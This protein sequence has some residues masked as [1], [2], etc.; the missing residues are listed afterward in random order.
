MKYFILPSL[1]LAALLFAP[2]AFAA[3]G[4]VPLTSIP[5]VDSV[6][7]AD[8]LAAFLNS[9]YK[10]AIGA[11][12]VLAVFQIIR[13]G[14]MYM[15][16]GSVLEK[17]EAKHHIFMAVVGLVLVLSPA[18]VF[19]II[20]PKI[21]DLNIG[22]DQLTP[23]NSQG[24]PG[25]DEG[26][27]GEDEGTDNGGAAEDTTVPQTLE[28]CAEN[29]GRWIVSAES[30]NGRCIIVTD[31]SDEAL[32]DEEQIDTT[33]GVTGTPYTGS[34][35]V[36]A[37]SKFV[38]YRTRNVPEWGCNLLS[39]VYFDS[40]A[41]TAAVCQARGAETG[42]TAINGAVCIPEG[43]SRTISLTNACTAPGTNEVSPQQANRGD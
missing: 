16:E 5:G 12:A 22:T 14:I 28:S 36:R 43:Q 25:Q 27:S 34:Y 20:N 21:L 30:P 7:G 6:T 11:A 10:L 35:T 9:L 32:T 33:N 23:G 19:G 41:T 4:F 39:S 29:Q 42:W 17:R 37:T 38:T 3:D 24:A 8:S 40:D 2:Q 13:G 26:Q 31:T 18:L 1:A 15:L